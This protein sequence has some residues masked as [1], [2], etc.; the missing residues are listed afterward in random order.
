MKTGL[1]LL[2]ITYCLPYATAMWGYV[3]S[4]S[5][6]FL[7]CRGSISIRLLPLY[8]E[9][10]TT[11]IKNNKDST[12]YHLDCGCDAAECSAG[13][14]REYATVCELGGVVPSADVDSLDIA[15]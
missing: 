15:P 14:R 8:N 6:A 13:D 1:E 5:L 10:I 9:K 11:T 4:L 2:A 12:V 7:Y 3:A